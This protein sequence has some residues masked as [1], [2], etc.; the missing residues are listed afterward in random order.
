MRILHSLSIVLLGLIAACGSDKPPPPPR[1]ELIQVMRGFADQACA[2][3]ADRE[4]LRTV[5]DGYDAQ[6]RDLR[7]NGLTGN[8]KASFDA[9]L[10]RLKLCGDG[11]GLTMWD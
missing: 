4:C 6:K 5:R 9:E 10:H 1:P 2:C 11:G 7:D 8:D 3:G